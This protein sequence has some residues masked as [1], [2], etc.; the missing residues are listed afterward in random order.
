MAT[1][2]LNE[3]IRDV[4]GSAPPTLADIERTHILF[5]NAHFRPYGDF[6]RDMGTFMTAS[7]Y[8]RQ[9]QEREA[10]RRERER[11]KNAR[12]KKHRRNR[13]RRQVVQLAHI[14]PGAIAR[15]IEAFLQAS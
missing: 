2:L 8:M 1:R 12:K 11:A 7:E 10:R 15:H 4:T 9:K 6:T 3:R 13:V 14:L 5:V